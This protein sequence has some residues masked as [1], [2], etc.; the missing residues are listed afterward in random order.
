MYSRYLSERINKRIGSGKAIVVIG[1][2]QVGKT[3]LIE[4]LL[5]S[6]EY[7]LLDGDD[8]K[9]RTILTEPNTE[10]IRTIL[11]KYKY[12][13][14]DEAQRIEGI[15]LTMKIITD[16]FK[17]VQLFT[18]GSSSF[19]LTNKINEPLTGRKWEY[20]LF[21]IS[22]EEFENHHGFLNA[23]QQLENRLLYGFYPDVLNNVGDE[24]SVLRNLVNS[25]LYKDILSNSDIRKPEVLDKL[26]QALALQV[27]S[28]VNFS[29][30]AQIVNVDKNTVGKYID[31]LEKGY[32]IFKLGSFSRNVRNEIKTNKKIYFYDNGVRNMVIGNFNPIDLRTDKGALWEN[33]LISERVKQIEYKQSLARVYFWR[34]KQQQEVDFVEDNGGEISGFEFKWNKKKNTRLPKTFIE[35]YNAK[36][37]VIDRENFRE[38]V[39]INNAS[40]QH[41]V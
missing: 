19:D 6:K 26:V 33:F 17:D 11:G 4:S 18:S 32:I 39:I 5:N 34:T 31:I 41:A 8:P 1:P 9:T 35:S 30:L 27:G 2:R 12:V 15:G 28:E 36:S 13:F 10:Q 37:Q 20:Q 29:E 21:P 3:T 16:R 14:I 38:F 24:V 25:Y 23:E 22:W 40:A 7:L